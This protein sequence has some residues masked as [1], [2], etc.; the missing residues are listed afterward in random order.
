MGA[1]GAV[2]IIFRKQIDASDDPEKARAELVNNFKQ[3]IDPYI[4]AGNAMVDD[5]ID[6]R[7]TRP[8]IIRGLEMAANKK[9]DRPWKKHGVMPV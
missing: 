7:E 5:I 6:P 8:T 1:E 2:N 3:I 4:A 9:I